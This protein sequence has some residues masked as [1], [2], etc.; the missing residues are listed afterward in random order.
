MLKILCKDYK[1]IDNVVDIIITDPPYTKKHVGEYEDFIRFCTSHATE[2][3][4]ITLPFSYVVL[5]DIKNFKYKFFT[6]LY[7]NQPSYMFQLKV[8]VR[9]RALLLLTQRLPHKTFINLTKRN[10]VRNKIHKWQ[11]GGEYVKEILTYF[12]TEEELKERSIMDPFGGSG[13]YLLP[14][15]NAKEVIYNDKNLK[16]AELFRS[17]LDSYKFNLDGLRVII[18]DD[19]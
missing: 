16:Y 8:L 9:A 15:L 19:F 4:L 7:N 2:F 6:F 18:D 12:Y 11:Q 17:R 13:D 14:F 1:E 3:V 10:V 5:P